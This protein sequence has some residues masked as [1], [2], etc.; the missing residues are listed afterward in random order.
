MSRALMNGTGQLRSAG[1]GT[2]MTVI[3]ASRCWQIRSNAALM[4]STMWQPPAGALH[5]GKAMWN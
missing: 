3:P 2:R 5:E 1:T 4:R